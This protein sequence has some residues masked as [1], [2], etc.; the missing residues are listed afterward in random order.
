[1]KRTGL[2]GTPIGA[3]KNG[4]E[5]HALRTEEQTLCSRTVERGWFKYAASHITCQRCVKRI[6]RGERHLR[7]EV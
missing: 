6:N 1:M 2:A 7:Q 5:V 3:S 4:G